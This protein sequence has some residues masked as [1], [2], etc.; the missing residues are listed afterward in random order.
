MRE[1]KRPSEIKKL[2]LVSAKFPLQGRDETLK[3]LLHGNERHNGICQR[4]KYIRENRDDKQLHH[5]PIL[6]N[7]PGTGKSRFLQELLALLLNHNVDELKNLKI[8]SVNITFN[9]EFIAL[10]D[11]IYAEPASV[12][13]RI[14]YEHFLSSKAIDYEDFFQYVGGDIDLIILGIDELKCLY[15]MGLP[16]TS[17]NPVQEIVHSVGSLA[18]ALEKIIYVPI[19]AGRIQGP[20]EKMSIESGY[21]IL[22]LPLHLLS[23]TE[24]INIGSHIANFDHNNKTSNTVLDILVGMYE[25][26]KFIMNYYQKK[27]VQYETSSCAIYPV[28]KN[29]E[30][31][32]GVT[33]V[34]LSSKGIINL[35]EVPHHP[36]MLFYVRMPYMWVWILI[37]LNEFEIGKFWDVIFDQESYVLWQGFEDFNMRFWVLRLQLFKVL[38]ETVTLENLFRGAYYG[39]LTFLDH[40]FHLPTMEKYYVELGYQYLYTMQNEHL[41]LGTVFKN[42]EGAPWDI[43]FFLDNYLIAIQVKSSNVTA[44]QPQTLSKW[45]VDK[46]YNKVNDAF[47]VMKKSF[48]SE[49][50]IKHW[51]LFICTNEPKTKDCLNS[52]PENY[53]V[54]Y[55]ENFKD[56]Y[57]YTFS[58]RA[59]FAAD[60]DQLDANIAEEYELK[61][62]RGIGKEI[63]FDIKN[64]RLFEDENDLY[65]KVKNIPINRTNS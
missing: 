10:E 59:E 37:S 26:W 63:T 21:N 64:E 15:S 42:G 20:L 7:G 3:V 16:R 46:E 50:P 61:T 57:G 53:F 52:L 18:T 36:N 44:G 41:S 11:E 30:I 12:A 51:V 6:T 65:N 38:Y 47:E 35:E 60:N 55:R 45:L 62:I 17:V 56:F 33:H 48:E 27:S 43:F 40:R 13:L 34:D 32:K 28:N 5:I 31:E 58:T 23:N 8:L 39:N 22:R 49:S 24:M 2:A 9:G 1:L 54:V 25:L 19:L 4:L 29:D 14:L